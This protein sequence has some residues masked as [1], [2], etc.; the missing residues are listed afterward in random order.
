[1]VSD[2]FVAGTVAFDRA[3]V[4]IGIALLLVG[5]HRHRGLR[6]FRVRARVG[7]KLISLPYAII[8][9]CP[10]ARWPLSSRTPFRAS[11]R[12]ESCN[13]SRTRDSRFVPCDASR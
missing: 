3:F 11:W 2:L 10:S 5:H 4:D 13:A 6:T 9:R 1:R 8:G 12:A 7:G